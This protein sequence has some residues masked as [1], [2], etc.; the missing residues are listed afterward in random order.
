[1]DFSDFESLTLR[2]EDDDEKLRQVEADLA[3]VKEELKQKPKRD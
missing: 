2:L 1:M 3:W